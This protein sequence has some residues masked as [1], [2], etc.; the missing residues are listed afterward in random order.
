MSVPPQGKLAGVIDAWIVKVVS[1]ARIARIGRHAFA[2]LLFKDK[3]W[4]GDGLRERSVCYRVGGEQT[5]KQQEARG[6]HRY[7]FWIDDGAHLTIVPRS[8]S[9]HFHRILVKIRRQET[10]EVAWRVRRLSI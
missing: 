3:I 2:G 5:G 9:A 1:Y 7:Y 4:R 10:V 6:F 8:I